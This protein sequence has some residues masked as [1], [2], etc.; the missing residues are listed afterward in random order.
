LS[1]Y[2]FFAALLKAIAKNFTT[3]SPFF[4]QSKRMGYKFQEAFHESYLPIIS[5]YEIEERQSKEVRN[6][7]PHLPVS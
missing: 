5:D 6:E 3:G 1:I 2:G 7:I 4:F